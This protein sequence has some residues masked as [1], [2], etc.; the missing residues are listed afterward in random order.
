MLNENDKSYTGISNLGPED[1]KSRSEDLREVQTPS[2]SHD[3]YE[4]IQNQIITSKPSDD[5]EIMENIR[6]AIRIRPERENW[7][8][9]DDKGTEENTSGDK[10]CI[11]NGNRCISIFNSGRYRSASLPHEDEL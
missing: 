1:H 11:Q 5:V 4:L 8:K 7:K 2:E 9:F 6:V 3:T 10:R